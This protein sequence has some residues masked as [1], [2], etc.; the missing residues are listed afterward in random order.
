[1]PNPTEIKQLRLGEEIELFDP[2]HG[3]PVRVRLDSWVPG[4]NEAIGTIVDFNTTARCSFSYNN[5]LHAYEVFIIDERDA[6][7]DKYLGLGSR[8][9]LDDWTPAIIGADA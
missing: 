2:Q 6:D 5:E 7:W 1:M 9:T 8:H 3:C 4:R